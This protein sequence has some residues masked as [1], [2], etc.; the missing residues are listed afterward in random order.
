MLVKRGSWNSH[1]PTEH[2]KP[3]N[4]LG[5][6]LLAFYEVTHAA[7]SLLAGCPEASKHT[8]I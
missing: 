6:G 7:I 2:V 5:K 4:T 1:V 3:H 8:P